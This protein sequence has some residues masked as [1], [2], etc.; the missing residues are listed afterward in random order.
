MAEQYQVKITLQA[1]AQMRDTFK[2]IAEELGSPESAQSWLDRIEKAFD[3][4]K[5]MPE[6]IALT[7]EEPW[8]SRG[9]HKMTVKN[10]LIYFWIDNEN[11]KVQITA[12]IYAGRDQ[13]HQLTQ[14]DME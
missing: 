4:L 13:I 8:R 3:S 9:I 14:M 12:I 5:V 6:R 1:I 7:E 10:H 2:Y 11:H